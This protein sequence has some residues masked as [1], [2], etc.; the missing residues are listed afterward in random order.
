MSDFKAKRYQNRFRLEFRTRPYWESLQRSQ[1]PL[2]GIKGPTSKETGGM[3]QRGEGEERR[4]GREERGGARE[5]RVREKR[6]GGAS[7]GDPRVC[8]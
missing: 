8:L 3:Q 7:R 5:R 6:G 2:A 4:G 1:D